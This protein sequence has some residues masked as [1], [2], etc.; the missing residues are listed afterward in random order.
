MKNIIPQHLYEFAKES[1]FLSK[2][3]KLTTYTRLVKL[4][5]I[6]HLKK[7][8]DLY[9]DS[10]LLKSQ[11][12]GHIT[13]ATDKNYGET[14]VSTIIVAKNFSEN[15]FIIDLEVNEKYLKLT[16]T[17]VTPNFK[18]KYDD[19][20]NFKITKA[21]F[22][23]DPIIVKEKIE[24]FVD[25]YINLFNPFFIAEYY[26]EDFYQLE[27]LKDDMT[28]MLSHYKLKSVK[29]NVKSPLSS[30][31]QVDLHVPFNILTIQLIGNSIIKD[32]VNY[33]D[34][35]V[36]DLRL[37]KSWSLKIGTIFI[38]FKV[39]DNNSETYL[40]I[41]TNDSYNPKYK[42]EVEFDNKANLVPTAVGLVEDYITDY[43][44]KQ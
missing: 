7:E 14:V 17:M 33:G 15:Y 28:S 23:A 6:E 42:K 35:I 41:I 26:N 31:T 18:N 19:L 25:N 3:N 10:S 12:A 38:D 29:L 40:L 20:K 30:E 36:T 39:L 44:L 8:Y 21:L 27:D 32:P 43:I 37:N 9:E 1:D 2:D 22:A 5:I 24:E 13:H 16:M 4:S 11:R 34:K